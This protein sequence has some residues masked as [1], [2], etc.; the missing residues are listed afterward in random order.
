[1]KSRVG[2]K[3]PR[4]LTCCKCQERKEHPSPKFDELPSDKDPENLIPL[5]RILTGIS[6]TP[7]D[8]IQDT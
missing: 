2:E 6:T 5:T 1:M 3:G 7:R 8:K 4:F